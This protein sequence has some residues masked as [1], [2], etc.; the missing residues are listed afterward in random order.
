MMSGNISTDKKTT[1][2]LVLDACYVLV[3]PVLSPRWDFACDGRGMQH[4]WLYYFSYLPAFLMQHGAVISFA[5][6]G[7]MGFHALL[8]RAR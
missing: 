8:G 7:Q 4:S 1:H 2:T 6:L 3:L 5:L